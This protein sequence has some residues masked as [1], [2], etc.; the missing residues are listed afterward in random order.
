MGV[1]GGK[2]VALIL[3]L[4]ILGMIAYLNTDFYSDQKSELAFWYITALLEL[5]LAILAF[6]L[7]KAKQKSDFKKA[8]RMTKFIMLS[9]ICFWFVLKYQAESGNWLFV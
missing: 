4:F 6:I 3:C 7:F 8:S 2:I 5:P 9:G 1:K